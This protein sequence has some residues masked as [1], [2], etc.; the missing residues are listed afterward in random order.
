V[1]VIRRAASLATVPLGTGVRLAGAA[2]RTALGANKAAVYDA[3]TAAS[4]D[5]AVATLSR[6]KGPAMKFGQSLAVFSGVLPDD[7]AAKFR[8]LEQLYE[9]AEPEPFSKLSSLLSVVP[10]GALEVDPTAV[11]AASLGQVHRGTWADPATGEKT[12]VAVKLR[13]P[14][15]RRNAKSDMAQLRALLPLISRLLP[16]LDLRALL[17]EHAARLEEELDYRNEAGWMTRFAEVWAEHDVYVPD[18]LF[19]SEAVLVSRWM[20]GTPLSEL[21]TAANAADSGGTAS[22]QD[23]RDRAGDL[24]ATFCL[25]SVGRVGAMHADPHPGNY[26]LLADGRLGVLDFGSVAH[27]TGQQGIGA[28][29]R[30]FVATAYL[31]THEQYAALLQVWI[32]AGMT[33]DTVTEAALIDLLDIDVTGQR[34]T[35]YDEGLFDFDPSWVAP[36]SE[37]WANPGAAMEGA[38]IIRFPPAYLLEHR[39]VMGMFALLTAL[40]AK[41]A[42]RELMDET[43]A[44]LGPLDGLELIDTTA[45]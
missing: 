33:A 29:T 44:D 1:G 18:V 42:M 17:D 28:F 21:I 15:A 8:A 12:D 19:A 16:N 10:A 3:A 30:L 32:D 2:T 7:L 26:R 38:R 40:R 45:H 6:I 20:D 4:I 35:P 13:Y 37:K 25:R 23:E 41:V 22:R 43:I 34:R 5:A 36:S 11:A 24:L 9:S 27:G 14:G 39:A 31:A